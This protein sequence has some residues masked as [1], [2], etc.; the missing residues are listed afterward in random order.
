VE[1]WKMKKILSIVA[2]IALATG[3]FPNSAAAATVEILKPTDGV[4][5]RQGYAAAILI[6]AVS[7]PEAFVNGVSIGIAEADTDIIKT[8]AAGVQWDDRGDMAKPVKYNCWKI[9]YQCDTAGTF[10]ITAKAGGGEASP[11]SIKVAAVMPVIIANDDFEDYTATEEAPAT[12]PNTYINW[13]TT[14]GWKLFGEQGLGGRE[15]TS[16]NIAAAVPVSPTLSALEVGYRTQFPNTGKLTLEIGIMMKELQ[17]TWI[18]LGQRNRLYNR[19]NMISFSP[20]GKIYCGLVSNT[21]NSK[22]FHDTYLR[23]Y[24]KGEWLDFKF[25]LDFDN[26]WVDY[27]INGV[28]YTSQYAYGADVGIATWDSFRY[29]WID[30]VVAGLY[31]DYHRFTSWL[32]A[33]EVSDISYVGDTVTTDKTQVPYSGLSAVNFQIS[34]LF[35]ATAMPL[36]SRLTMLYKGKEYPVPVTHSYANAAKIYSVVP[37]IELRPDTEYILEF[38]GS[39]GAGFAYLPPQTVN[40]RTKKRS[41]NVDDVTFRK[42]GDTVTATPAVTGGTM[43]IVLAAYAN[44]LLKAIVL[45]TS[46]DAADCDKVVAYPLTDLVNFQPT[47]LSYEYEVK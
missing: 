6:D 36:E 13:A 42:S 33:P 3:L 18:Q 14:S 5:V 20:E 37:T 7:A 16:L 45:G 22:R 9:Y 15:G 32:K 29:M 30:T 11:V 4:E 39:D 41:I 8:T 26:K 2:T 27:Y 31:V 25:E 21:S 23:D 46:I 19:W 47:G 10:S 12:P 28:Q 17:T 44:G 43:R 34:P 24:A 1:V 38:P 40:F 35:T